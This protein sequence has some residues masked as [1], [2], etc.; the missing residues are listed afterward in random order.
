MVGRVACGMTVYSLGWPPEREVHL[1]NPRRLVKH[2]QQLC[3]LHRWIPLLAQLRGNEHGLPSTER[4][5]LVAYGHLQDGTVD[6]LPRLGRSAMEY[7]IRKPR[8]CRG[9]TL[10]LATDG[11]PGLAR[12]WGALPFG[13]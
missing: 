1:R 5:R 9:T 10:A 2:L 11:R 13:G 12:N 7:D 3:T 8:N 4:H 6:V